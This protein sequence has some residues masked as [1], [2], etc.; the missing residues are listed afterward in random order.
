MLVRLVSNS[1][2]QVIRLPRSP[3]VLGLQMKKL[4]LREK[5]LTHNK[6]WRIVKPKH[7][8]QALRLDY[9]RQLLALVTR[10]ECNGGLSAHCNLCLPGSSNTLPQSP[11]HTNSKVSHRCYFTRA[12]HSLNSFF[13]GTKSRLVARL[14]C[15]GVS[16]A[17]CNLRLPGSSNSP[18]SASQVAGT[19]GTCHHIQLFFCI[20]NREGFHHVSQDGVDLLTSVSL[21]LRLECNGVISAHGN[22]CLPGSNDSPASTS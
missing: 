3:K 22:L 13:G 9:K 15:S 14:E 7:T 19:T 1:R 17:H 18:A 12:L 8:N 11:K 2:P 6:R 4:R 20:F 5:W 16:S 10:L 21:L